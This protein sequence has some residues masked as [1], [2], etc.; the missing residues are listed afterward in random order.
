M[1]RGVWQGNIHTYLTFSLH[2]V[3][4]GALKKKS[5]RQILIEP[6]SEIEPWRRKWQPTPGFVLENSI[7]EEPGGLCSIGSQRVGHN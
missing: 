2:T 7:E 6:W 3:F 1:D 4:I 5:C